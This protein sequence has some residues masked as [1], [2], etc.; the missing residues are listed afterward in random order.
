MTG[1]FFFCY[2]ACCPITNLLLFVQSVKN[3]VSPVNLLQLLQL[4]GCSK[5]EFLMLRP[6]FFHGRY[7]VIIYGGW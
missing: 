6:K 2:I 4:I 1:F 5:F 7:D 3:G